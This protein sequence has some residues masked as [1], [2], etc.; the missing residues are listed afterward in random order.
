M[1][2]DRLLDILRLSPGFVSGEQI[3]ETLGV[4]RT[5]V[6][7]A[8]N[9]LRKKGCRIESVTNRGYRLIS[10]DGIADKDPAGG[11]CGTVML[12]RTMHYFAQCSST[13]DKAREG[14]MHADSEG[15]VYITDWQTDG[16]GRMGRSWHGDAGKVIL[17]SVLLKPDVSPSFI[18]PISL[19][20]GLAV[21]RA[22]EETQGLTCGLK[23]PNDILVNSAKIGGILIETSTSGESVQYIALGIGINCNNE[24]FPEDLEGRAS[25][26]FLQ[27]GR[28]VSRRALICAVLRHLERYYFDWISEFDESALLSGESVDFSYLKEY[29][30]R[31][32]NLGR[33][34]EIHQ[35][36]GILPAEAVDISPGGHLMVRLPDGSTRAVLSGEVSLRVPGGYA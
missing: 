2:E 16:R 34:V 15:T 4:S 25:S 29:R 1:T 35:H 23:W 14:G 12:G 21:C 32:L 31:C 3:S 20:A 24:Q 8:V 28:P 9:R 30:A 33:P 7:K 19:F 13:N 6:W 10:S 18:M 5:A 11:S 36:G 26:V 22:L 17:M 27:T